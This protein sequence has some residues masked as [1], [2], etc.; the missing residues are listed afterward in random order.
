MLELVHNRHWHRYKAY[1]SLHLRARPTVELS[2]DSGDRPSARLREE[3]GQ[4]KVSERV[5]RPNLPPCHY[6]L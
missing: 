1:I 3:G 4:R 6:R 2:E 5:S